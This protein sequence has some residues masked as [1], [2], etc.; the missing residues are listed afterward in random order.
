MKL[1]YWR[2]SSVYFFYF[3]VVGA[4]APFWGLYLESL[5]YGPE[6]I[7]LLSALPVVT[8][9]IAPNIWGWLAD[10]TGR[11]LWL[12]RV[13]AFGG[14]FI[15]AGIFLRTDYAALIWVILGYS[16]FWNAI[17]SQFEVI[18]LSHLG[19]QPHYYS[20]IRLWGSVGFIA[21][22]M[23]LGVVFDLISVRFLPIFI[24]ILLLC[25]GFAS[26]CLPQVNSTITGHHQGNLANILRRR[27]VWCFLLA[28]FFLQ[29]SHG[30]YYTFYSIYLE[31]HHYSRTSIGLLWAL[32][33]VAEIFIFLRMHYLMRRFNLRQLLLFSLSLAVIRW[34]MIGYY[35]DQ[36]I[37][38][39]IAQLFHAATFGIAH[40]VAIE[41]VRRFF[42]PASQGQGQ[43]LYSG[44]SF[45]TGTA[46]GA[47]ISGQLW[48]ISETLAFMVAS[49]AA[50]LAWFTV[51]Y[52]VRK[53]DL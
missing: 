8:K 42:G 40:A 37:L 27:A 29:F 47:Y 7:G 43:A 38:V 30:V 31:A 15:F 50:L 16:F 28:T 10:K 12:I 41:L 24:L 26:L 44:V 18:T 20:R 19:D 34:W 25:I 51:A 46:A 52:G 22:V 13:G 32:G 23:I 17:I 3:A 53:A 39:I 9:I 1:P 14:A 2:L 35:V 45:G 11:R 36:P 5:G 33:V 21:T 48:S 6:A 49:A 4:L